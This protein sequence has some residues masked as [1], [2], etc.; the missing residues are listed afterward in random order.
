[1]LRGY[2]F[3]FQVFCGHRV[4]LG[5]EVDDRMYD[6]MIGNDADFSKLEIPELMVLSLLLA[7]FS[8]ILF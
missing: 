8:I 7:P 2:V 4:K 6:V 1:M 5:L 3:L